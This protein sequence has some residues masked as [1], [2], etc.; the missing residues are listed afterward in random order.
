[1]IYACIELK[2]GICI[3]QIFSGICTNRTKTT[4]TIESDYARYTV[5][6]VAYNLMKDDRDG[7]REGNFNGGF[8]A[9]NFT[10]GNLTGGQFDWGAI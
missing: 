10:G 5:I 1:M 3:K 9:G 8:T 6:K 2:F 7:L 4:G